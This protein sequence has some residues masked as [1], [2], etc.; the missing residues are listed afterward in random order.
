MKNCVLK[1]ILAIIFP[2]D[3][4]KIQQ[5]VGKTGRMK[6]DP[7]LTPYAKINSIWIKDMTC[8]KKTVKPLEENRKIFMTMNL[9]MIFWI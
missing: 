7:D 3:D 2:N 4:H 6:L 9:A 5:V 1:I 8:R